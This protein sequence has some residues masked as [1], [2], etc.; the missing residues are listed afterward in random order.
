[1]HSDVQA[2]QQPIIKCTDD[3]EKI[4]NDYSDRLNQADLRKLREGLAELKPRY[5]NVSTQS[6]DRLKKL[7]TGID[8]VQKFEL[9]FSQ[10]LEWLRTAEQGLDKKERNVGEDLGVL[11]KQCDEHR[12][13]ADDVNDQKGDIRFL[14]KAGQNFLDQAKV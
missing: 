3:I 14:T 5:D 9:D 13:F 10:F 1:M 4:L 6:Y 12:E 8:D 7:S 11:E 2:H